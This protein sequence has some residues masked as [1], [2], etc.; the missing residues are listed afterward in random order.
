[1]TIDEAIIRI[2]AHIKSYTR[3]TDSHLKII[4]ALNLAV[5]ALKQISIFSEQISI[6]SEQTAKNSVN[7]YQKKAEI[8]Q[9]SITIIHPK[10]EKLENEQLVFTGTKNELAV[11]LSKIG[12]SCAFSVEPYKEKEVKYE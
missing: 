7:E 6:F 1:M 5:D 4:Y 12:I 8:K 10:E 2:K 11:F 3:K 9:W